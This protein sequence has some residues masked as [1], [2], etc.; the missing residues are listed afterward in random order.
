[1]CSVIDYWVLRKGYWI[2]SLLILIVRQKIASLE[3]VIPLIAIKSKNFRRL[4]LSW[5]IVCSFVCGVIA[6]SFAITPGLPE[7]AGVVFC[8]LQKKWVKGGSQIAE[9]KPTPLSEICSPVKDKNSF[10]SSLISILNSRV[11]EKTKIDIATLFFAFKAKGN[12]AFS[13]LPSDPQLPSAPVSVNEV[14]V[15]AAGHSRGDVIAVL[16]PFFTLEQL[17]RPPTEAVCDLYFPCVAE[18]PAKLVA[19]NPRGPP[20][21]LA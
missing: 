11:L 8:P 19:I 16:S 2:R 6:S 10:T 14:T 21:N 13:D 20:S 12:R 15:P 5:L 4:A 9:L 1:M 3:R 18:L 17:S 7:N